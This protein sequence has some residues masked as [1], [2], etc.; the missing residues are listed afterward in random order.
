MINITSSI[1]LSNFPFRTNKNNSPGVEWIQKGHNLW[2]KMWE[3]FDKRFTDFHTVGPT[4][5]VRL[6]L[7]GPFLENLT[8]FQPNCVFDCAE[9]VWSKPLEESELSYGH[10]MKGDDFCTKNFDSPLYRLPFNPK[11]KKKD[12]NQSLNRSFSFYQREWILMNI[13]HKN[14]ETADFTDWVLAY[15][16]SFEYLVSSLF[17]NFDSVNILAFG[18]GALNK[19]HFD[20]L[21]RIAH[22]CEKFKNISVK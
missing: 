5:W 17:K 22:H 9:D 14:V 10:A 4:I 11:S 16:Q 19:F 18:F 2:D 12:N 1:T 6:P 7:P 8:E 15:D 21:S 13:P 3:L 20:L